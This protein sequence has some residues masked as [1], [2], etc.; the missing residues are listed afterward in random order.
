MV[1][2]AELDGFII[3]YRY[4]VLLS[5]FGAQGTVVPEQERP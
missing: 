1:R 5:S 2:Q 3:D 4:A